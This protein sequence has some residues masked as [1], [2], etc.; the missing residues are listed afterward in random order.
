MISTT[1]RSVVVLALVIATAL[2][3]DNEEAFDTVPELMVA[4]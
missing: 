1:T 4:F 2:C 3:V